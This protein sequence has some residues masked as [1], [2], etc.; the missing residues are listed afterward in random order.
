[1]TNAPASPPSLVRRAAGITAWNIA[2]RLTGFVRVILVGGALG[3][4]FL[5]NT[6]QSAN[7]V[8]NVLF[9]LL[10]AGMLGAV[11]VPAIV[12]R[13]ASGTRAD[14]RF[15]AGAVLGRA[16]VLLTPVV[17]VGVLAAPWLMRAL[18]AGVAD[19]GVRADQ[20]RLGSFLLVFFLPQI[21][22]YAVLAVT[23]AMLQ[24]DGRFAAAAA[25]PV[26]N[27][28]VVS[29]TLA[30]FWIR[31]GVGLDLALVDR[32]VLA[33]GTTAGVLAMTVVPLVAARRADLGLRPHLAALPE[34]RALWRSGVWAAA[35]LGATQILILT[36]VVLAN[37]VEG[38]VV[39]YQI[40]YTFFLL[41]HAL[42]AHPLATALFP[43]LAADAHRADLSAFRAGLDEGMTLLLLAL[44]PVSGLLVG[45]APV[46]VEA[47][48]VGALNRDVGVTLVSGALSMYGVGLVGYSALLLLTR[49]AYAVDDARAPAL[50]YCSAVAT[51]IGLMVALALATGAEDR[52]RVLGAV[53]TIVVLGAAV[54]L[55]G[56]LARRGL[57]TVRWSLWARSAAWAAAAGTAARLAALTIA[58]PGDARPLQ[59][60][61]TV[62][63]AGAGAVIYL[64]GLYVTGVNV[65]TTRGRGQLT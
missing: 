19:S 31:G 42:V 34:L 62:L 48:S 9:E 35:A 16:L 3:A 39:A 53:H 1:M 17:V 52:V 54:V 26:A 28:V 25:A 61:A 56:V 6:Y 60:A 49:A 15:L 13:L 29:A 24:A 46:G 27:N 50:I 20:I 65:V 37:A 44:L 11:L 21:L 40:A 63:G 22:L 41:P 36:T 18:S 45:L 57:L 59:L 33:A 30:W 47:V 51:G 23:T 8:S 58:A 10:A 5:G 12:G 38:G 2:A 7:V 32:V 64:A 4:T 55:G 14:A 43:R